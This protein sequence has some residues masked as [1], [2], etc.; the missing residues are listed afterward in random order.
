MGIFILG[1][2]LN[3]FTNPEPKMKLFQQAGVNFLDSLGPLVTLIPLYMYFPTPA[4]VGFVN[5]VRE[6]EAIS[7]ELVD[8]RMAKL[9]A[10]M[11]DGVQFEATC[12]LDQWLLDETMTRSEMFTLVRDFLAAGIDTVGG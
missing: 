10:M 3:L 2:R 7:A 9:K 8:E 12:F 4:S 5:A 6:I 1:E 11:L